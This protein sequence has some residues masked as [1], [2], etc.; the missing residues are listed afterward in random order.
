MHVVTFCR[1]FAVSENYL[2][3]P[4]VYLSSHA[5]HVV[6]AFTVRKQFHINE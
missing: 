3:R 1:S 4:N 2:H 5:L 6:T